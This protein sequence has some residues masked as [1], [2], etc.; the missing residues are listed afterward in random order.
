MK[1]VIL[2]RARYVRLFP[3]EGGKMRSLARLSRCRKSREVEASSFL[4]VLASRG[5]VW[6]SDKQVVIL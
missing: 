6:V 2:G 3:E 5:Q 4:V 1:S